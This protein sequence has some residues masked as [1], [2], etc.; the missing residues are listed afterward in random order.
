[1]VY[2]IRDQMFIKV[3]ETMREYFFSHLNDAIRLLREEEE[4]EKETRK[5]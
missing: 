2:A 5:D 3:L 4:E 1:M